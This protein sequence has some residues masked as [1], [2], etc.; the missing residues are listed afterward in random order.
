MRRWE[1]GEAAVSRFLW[2]GQVAAAKPVTVVEDTDDLVALYIAPGTRF[3]RVGA[4]PK[5]HALASRRWRLVDD[6]WTARTLVLTRPGAAHCILGFWPKDGGDLVTWYVN[7]EDPLRHSPLGFDGRDVFLDILIKPNGSWRWKDED[8]FAQA[9]H[10]GLLSRSEAA[11]IRA[12][13]ER[14]IEDAESSNAWWL[15]WRAWTPDPF[16]QTPELLRGW[17]AVAGTQ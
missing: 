11:A 13:G 3:K 16:W 17:D 6:V 7:L 1:R 10:L 9:Q 2:F 15:Q 5:V 8:E 4:D 12:E 14:V